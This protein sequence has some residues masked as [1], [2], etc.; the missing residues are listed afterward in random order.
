MKMNQL[1]VNAEVNTGNY[2]DTPMPVLTQL[3]YQN[4]DLTPTMFLNSIMSEQLQRQGADSNYISQL[5][6]AKLLEKSQRTN[7]L[8]LI[9]KDVWQCECHS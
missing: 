3:V 4:T 7:N 2:N 5:V 9:W 1:D 6:L 8:T